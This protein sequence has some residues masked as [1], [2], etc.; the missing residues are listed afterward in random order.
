MAIKNPKP[1]LEHLSHLARQIVNQGVSKNTHKSYNLALK[2]LDKFRAEYQLNS[3]WPIAISELLNFIAYLSV[4]GLSG[5]SVSSYISGISYF[6]KI[7]GFQ[8][9][10]KFFIISKALEG[11]KRMQGGKRQDI[12][13]PITLNLLSEIT[14]VLDKVCSS[15]YEAIMFA[16]AFSLSFFGLLRVGEIT[17][18]NQ[19][20]KIKSV[21]GIDDI[22]INK[23]KINLMIRCSKTDQQGKS[24]KLVIPANHKSTCPVRLIKKYLSLRPTGSN[25]DLFIHFNSSSLTR[26]Q[27]N[28]VLQKS[29]KFLNVLKGHY[30]THSFRIGGATELAR[31]GV[32]EQEIMKLGRWKS[33]AYARYIRIDVF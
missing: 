9:T 1:D 8:D 26:Y 29:L 27:F 22:E 28:S 18:P 16:A 33:H 32:N 4:N 6:H 30:R 25:Q 13:A 15:N 7:N 21:I 10:T 23:N 12:R 19:K 17:Q 31:K 5:G 2:K 11:L 20:E 3:T 14:S 24:I